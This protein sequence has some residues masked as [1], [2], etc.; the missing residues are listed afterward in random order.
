MRA[1]VVEEAEDI[2]QTLESNIDQ[3]WDGKESILELK[4]ADYQWR[5]MEWIG[6]YFEHK[7]FVTL[8][9]TLGGQVGPRVGNTQ[10]DFKK[11]YVWD[12]KSHPKNSS[13]NWAI[14]NDC[15]AVNVCIEKY[16]GVGFIIA[17]GEAK[18]NDEKGTFRHWHS[19]LKGGPS[20]YV[21]KRKKRGAS[22]RRRKTRFTVIDYVI[23]FLKSKEDIE[24]AIDEGWLSGDAQVGWRNADG[25]PRR[26]K[27]KLKVDSV[28]D[29]AKI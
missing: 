23:I 19:V 21:K 6:F 10:F 2:R 28:S 1:E 18:Y 22:S 3:V 4:E 17:M 26:A 8:V 5:Q 13:S 29:W 25:S 16:G 27:Y 24:R 20:E 11:S 14:T 12:F 7:A 15:E 9:N